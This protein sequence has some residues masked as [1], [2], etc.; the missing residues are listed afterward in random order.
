MKIYQSFEREDLR[1][2]FMDLTTA[3]LLTSLYSEARMH[4]VLK[5]KKQ[6]VTAGQ[7]KLASRSEYL[8]IAVEQN[9]SAL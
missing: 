2:A 4:W 5:A 8:A 1:Q 7:I 3:E 6:V 9:T